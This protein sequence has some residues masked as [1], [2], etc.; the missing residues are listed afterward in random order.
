MNRFFNRRFFYFDKWPIVE[1][2]VL[3]VEDIKIINFLHRWTFK[4]S[5]KDDVAAWS[6]WL[7]E[8]KDTIFSI[9]EKLYGN[10]HHYWI[11][12]MMNNMIDYNFRWPMN[13][14][15]L[16]RFV[17]DKYGVENT[18]AYHH[19][20]SAASSDI[21]ALPEGI[22]VDKDYSYP[23]QTVSNMEHEIT[24]N[25]ERRRIK[26]LDPKWLPQVLKER[27]RITSDKFTSPAAIASNVLLMALC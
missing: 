23:R 11:I 3:G 1:G 2:Y 13:E 25:D 16:Y 18:D 22:I 12:M 7:I 5:V 8:D 14:E 9:A 10:I 27:N 4:N 24:L 19:T 17:K 20:L 26:L 6:S 21:Y 15:E